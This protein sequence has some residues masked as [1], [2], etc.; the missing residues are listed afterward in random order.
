MKTIFLLP[1]LLVLY[2]FNN[3]A[4]S[5]ESIDE[6]PLFISS[7]I[8][9]LDGKDLYCIS[10]YK[11]STNSKSR[12]ALATLEDGTIKYLFS[13]KDVG[14]DYRSWFINHNQ[15]YYL[16]SLTEND[17]DYVLKL[18][19]YDRNFHVTDSN[20]LFKDSL[21]KYKNSCVYFK[22]ED[23]NI[24][25]VGLS[26]TID[27][28]G[29]VA[30][31]DL[32]SKKSLGKSFSIPSYDRYACVDF[33]W[34]NQQ[35]LIAVF[36]GSENMNT[37]YIDCKAT[38]QWKSYL[39]KLSSKEVLFTPISLVNE[40][41]AVRSFKL[42]KLN[43]KDIILGG[44]VFAKIGEKKKQNLSFY[45]YF[46]SDLD[47]VGAELLNQ[48]F[49]EATNVFNSALWIKSQFNDFEDGSYYKLK[50]LFLKRISLLNN[51]DLLF[52]SETVISET[53]ADMPSRTVSTTKM[54][55]SSQSHTIPVTSFRKVETTTF[56]SSFTREGDIII[57][58]VSRGKVDWS[59]KPKSV[60]ERS[61]SRRE[62]YY[63]SFPF[64]F[65]AELNNEKLILFYSEDTKAFNDKG[66]L[67]ETHPFFGSPYFSVVK[68]EVNLGTGQ[69]ET[70]AVFS[71]FKS[72]KNDLV[73]FGGSFADETGINIL[74]YSYK[75]A[76]TLMYKYKMTIIK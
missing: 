75:G 8:G 40:K 57:S 36:E 30:M 63:I 68:F 67:K 9:E 16:Y 20:I 43:E 28:L 34:N 17:E 42:V 2:F 10:N 48:E 53:G 45:G 15:L 1:L 61:E 65:L 3:R 59:T 21:N 24:S 44:L 56:G 31:L 38:E 71:D 41:M 46:R 58:R 51:N 64:F 55:T 60:Y 26:R 54:S 27:S 49:L 74:T 13:H 37:S 70:K 72:R 23:Y 47:F 32:S 5:Q 6:T 14:E 19:Q 7:R 11:D 62:S 29:F 25:V 33:V 4:F 12:Y 18:E 50:N 69:G 66:Q 76:F 22:C 73:N 52:I 35:E 39:M